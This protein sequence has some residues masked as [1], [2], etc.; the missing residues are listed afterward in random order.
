[1]PGPPPGATAPLGAVSVNLRFDGGAGV[2]AVSVVAAAGDAAPVDS[3][4]FDWNH[5]CLAGVGE[6]AAGEPATEAEAVAF[7]RCLCLAG[8]GDTAAGEPAIE[9]AAVGF[10]ACLCFPGDGLGL[11]VAVCANTADTEKA[12]SAMIRGMSFFIPYALSVTIGTLQTQNC[13]GRRPIICLPGIIIR[14]RLT[15]WTN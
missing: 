1:M 13:V 10:F 7:F 11:E 2:G 4:C 8:E 3:G 6:P 15:A 9:A 14:F 5:E 12:V